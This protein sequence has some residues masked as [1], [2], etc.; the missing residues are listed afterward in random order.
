M[1]VSQ[2]NYRITIELTLNSKAHSQG[3]YLQPC[4]RLLAWRGGGWCGGGGRGGD[5]ISSPSVHY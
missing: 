1:V 5:L 3:S 2:N 4:P